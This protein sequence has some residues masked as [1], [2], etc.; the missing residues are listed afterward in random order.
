MK[1]YSFNVGDH[2]L[3]QHN[4]S[5][6]EWEDLDDEDREWFIQYQGKSGYIKQISNGCY[7]V[8][9]QENPSQHLWCE[10]QELTAIKKPKVD[11]QYA[12]FF[13]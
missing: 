12:R 8:L 2:V 10:P 1:T 6:E 5:Q 4:F 3:F 7:F 11:E 13:V 9:F